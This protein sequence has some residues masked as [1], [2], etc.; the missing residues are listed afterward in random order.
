MASEAIVTLVQLHAGC[1]V[2]MER[3]AGHAIMLDVDSIEFSHLSCGDVLLHHFEYRWPLILFCLIAF[4]LSNYP[5]FL[6]I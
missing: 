6:D 2:V 1:F 4:G 5:S 3:A